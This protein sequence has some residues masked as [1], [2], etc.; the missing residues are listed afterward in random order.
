MQWPFEEWGATAVLSGHDHC[1]ERFAAGQSRFP[2][3]VNG[4]GGARIYGFQ[5]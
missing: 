5:V 1:Y 2:Y 3:F 4:M